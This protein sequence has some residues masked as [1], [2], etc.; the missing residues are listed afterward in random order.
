MCENKYQLV[1]EL[2]KNTDNN[3]SINS[4]LLYELQN[5]LSTMRELSYVL[6]HK[7]KNLKKNREKYEN[8]WTYYFDD[9]KDF[10]TTNPFTYLEKKDYIMLPVIWIGSYI[11]VY[12][13]RNWG[14]LI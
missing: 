13:Y 11:L 1:S 9:I 6:Q 14:N 5:M 2:K 7:L 3:S 8:S 10:F 12:L 4:D